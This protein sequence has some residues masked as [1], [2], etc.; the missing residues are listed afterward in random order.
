M[1]AQLSAEP[2]GLPEPPNPKRTHL[3]DPLVIPVDVDDTQPVVKRSLGDEEIGERRPV[4]HPMVMGK[5][6]LQ[7]K[8]P[9]EDVR[10]WRDELEGVVQGFFERVVVA[11]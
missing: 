10:W 7:I 11:R 6:P 9:V 8:R 2:R 3:G 4:P 5:I 1:D